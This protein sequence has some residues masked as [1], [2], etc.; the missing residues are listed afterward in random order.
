MVTMREIRIGSAW[1]RLRQG[2]ITT[3]NVDAI[4]NAANSQLRGG[5]G[6]DGAIHQAGGPTIMQEC[7]QIGQCATGSA[8]VTGAGKLS[9]HF[10]IHAV[11]PIWGGGNRREAELLASA[12]QSSLNA[13]EERQVRTI[14]F[15]S[16]STG[17]YGYPLEPAAKIAL[18]TIIRHLRGTSGLREAYMILYRASDLAV[19]EQA[20]TD[21]IFSSQPV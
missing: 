12:Y 1:L 2:D 4:V 15:P 19:Y 16:I 13:A 10:V 3:C 7:R 21:I 17:A 9:A 5:G 14:A 11:G 6:V 18:E 8:C 20:L